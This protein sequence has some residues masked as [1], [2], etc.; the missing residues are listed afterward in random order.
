MTGT[1]GSGK[2]TL[3]ARIAATLDVPH[4]EIDSLFHGPSWTKRPSFEEDVH[5]FSAGPSW[6]TEWQY[7]SVLAHLA[8]RAD[9]LVWL[10]LPRRTVMRRVVQRTLTRRLR[11]QVLW[12]GNI[13][14][15]LRTFFT[16]DEHIIRW[17]WKTHGRTTAR[18]TNLARQRPDL[19]VVRLRTT[20][21]ADR[22]LEG[23]LHAASIPQG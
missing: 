6:V 20:P 17:A 22:W 3:A 11:R 18:V 4:I 7:D 23:P 13:E 5:R 8:G 16:D 21:A 15:P 19:P 1:S 9:L 10:D 12:N 2:T 14:P